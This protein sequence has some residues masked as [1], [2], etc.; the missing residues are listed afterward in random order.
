MVTFLYL[1]IAALVFFVI[2]Y[3][4]GKA[5][6]DT[7]A[8]RYLSQTPVDSNTH[9][10][11]SCE[12]ES[13]IEPEADASDAGKKDGEEKNKELDQEIASEPV[14]KA[15][16][17]ALEKDTKKPASVDKVD[18][19][20]KS[21]STAQSVST[22]AKTESI[23]QSTGT[24]PIDLL[25]APRDGKKDNIT[26]IK[27]IGLK[28]EENLNDIGVYHFD[29]IAAW[30]EQNT[31]WA[32]SQLSFPGRAKREDWTGQAKLLAEGKETEFSKRV[33]KGE[34]PSSKKA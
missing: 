15:T 7:S 9:D 4:V 32:D 31:A 10:N 25:D 13:I 3:L 21:V 23:E 16:K 17:T 34:V 8:D 14:K 20:T 27:G 5:K 29:Q 11:G 1:L 6:C 24:K 18:I 2:G 33:D 28:I 22:D 12:E 26:R 30:T 19:E